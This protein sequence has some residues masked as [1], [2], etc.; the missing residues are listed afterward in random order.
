MRGDQSESIALARSV[1]IGRYRRREMSP[2]EEDEFERTLFLDPELA[3][4]TLVD[5]A[6]ADGF[7]ALAAHGSLGA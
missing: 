7:R 2:A 4:H 5:F 3:T 6:I 1:E